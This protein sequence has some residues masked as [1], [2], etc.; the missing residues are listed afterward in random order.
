MPRRKRKVRRS[1][2][3]RTHEIA[4]SFVLRYDHVHFTESAFKHGIPEVDT[5]HSKNH[6]IKI[7][8]F[9]DD[10]DRP[11]ILMIGPDK[12]GNLLELLMAINPDSSL[13]IFHAMRLR[14]KFEGLINDQE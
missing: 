9:F 6:A 10:L 4:D 13:K 3:P 2:Q 14:P 5:R 12:S 7:F 8:K 11:R 1:L